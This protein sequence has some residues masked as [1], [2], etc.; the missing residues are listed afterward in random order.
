MVD[1]SPLKTR[2]VE[3]TF[4]DTLKAYVALTKPRIAVMLVFTAAAAMVVAAGGVPEWRHALLGL[5]G[6]VLSAGGSAAVNMWYDR[7]IDAV[8]SRTSRRPLPAGVIAPGRA[9]AFGLALGLASVLVLGFGVNWLTAGLCLAGYVYYAW[10]YTMVLK[11]HTPQNIV[12]GGGAGSFPP[13]VGWAA[14]TGHVSLTA[15]L[16]FAVI[17]LWTPPHFWALAL[18]K[19]ADYKRAGVPM[20]PVSRGSRT[21][22]RQMSVYAVLLLAASLALLPSVHAKLI[23]AA[24]A[25]I[26]GGAFLVINLRLLA[27]PDDEMKW[28]KRTFFASLLYVPAIFLAIVLCQF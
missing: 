28:A 21:T 23:Y 16:M 20:M 10:F 9:L 7:D 8:M 26:Q 12:V 2:P 4:M 25:V 22:K 27:A 18:Y 24:V 3:P 15:W 1:T 11:R 13:L 17:F 5:I 6:L 14:V 19:N